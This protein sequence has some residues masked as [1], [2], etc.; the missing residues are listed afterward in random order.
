MVY[1][2]F[3]RILTTDKGKEIK[4]SKLHHLMLICLS[5]ETIVTREELEE[6]TGSFNIYKLKCDF[7]KRV[8]HNIKIRTVRGI[9]FI[10]ESKIYFE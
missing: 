9:G 1:N 8:K 2:T 10:L 5:N 7:L 6:F 4:L 3:S